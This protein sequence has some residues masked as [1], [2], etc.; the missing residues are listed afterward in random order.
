MRYTHWDMR[1]RSV[2]RCATPALRT[3]FHQRVR[4]SGVTTGFPWVPGF[5]FTCT[6]EDRKRALQ[7]RRGGFLGTR[8]CLHLHPCEVGSACRGKLAF[9]PSARQRG[10]RLGDPR[11]LAVAESGGVS[12]DGRPTDFSTQALVANRVR[13][14]AG[15]RV[16]AAAQVRRFE[17][18][19][20]LAAGTVLPRCQPEQRLSTVCF[21]VA[22]RRCRRSGHADARGLFDLL[23]DLAVA[24]P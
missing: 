10:R 12:V 15:I 11:P 9:L 13:P 24:A 7:R 23:A 6:A 21:S 8:F 20:H 2:T 3:G 16:A 4:R 22:E 18:Q 1:P 14:D 19:P 17:A 5:A